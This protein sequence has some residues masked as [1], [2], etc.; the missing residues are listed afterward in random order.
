[1]RKISTYLIA[2]VSLASLAHIA[3]AMAQD[4]AA[5]E[6]TEAEADDGVI[7]VNARRRDES[8]QDV[9]A[10]VNAVSSDVIEK[11]NLRKLQDLEA[12]VPGLSLVPNANGIGSVSTVR[13]VDF[14]VNVSGNNGTIEFYLNDAPLSSGPVF[15]SM[16]DVGQ[17]EVLRGPQ[18]TLKGRASPSGAI[19]IN[20]RKPDLQEVGGNFN[21]TMNDIGGRNVNG[22]LN[23]PIVADKLAVRI[24][25]VVSDDDGSEVQP[26]NNPEKLKNRSQGI[27]AS[28]RSDPFDGKFIADFMYQGFRRKGVQYDQVASFNEIVAGG[29]A[30]PVFIRARDRAAV[31]GF[32]RTNDQ[33]FKIYNWTLQGAL[34]GQRLTYTGQRVDQRLISFAPSDIAGI[35]AVDTVGT[36]RFGQPTDTKANGISHEVRLQNDER[37][38]GIFDYVVGYLNYKNS[39]DTDLFSPTGI[40]IGAPFA[41]PPRLVNIALTPIRRFGNNVEKSIFGNVSAHIGDQFE[42]SGGLRDI[43]YNNVAGLAIG[44]VINPAFN[45]DEKLGK[46]IYSAS[47]KFKF[48]DNAMVYAN[49]GTSWRP[50][51]IAI[52]TALSGAIRPQQAAFLKTAD[53]TSK[54]Y[55]IGLKTDL[56]DRKLRFNLSLYQQ[57]FQNYPY[58]A[59]TGVYTLS[60]GNNSIQQVNFV[61]GVPVKVTGIEAE[62]SAKPMDNFSVGAVFGYAK[63]N[64]SNGIIPCT[65]LN[66]DG[67]PDT[68]AAAPTLAQLEAAVG[69]V[70]NPA[71]A[72]V[73]SCTTS[74]RSN[75]SP[76]FTA[77]LNSEYTASLGNSVDGFVRGLYIYKGK[78][79]SDPVNSFDDQGAFGLLNMY[80]GV[81]DPD[82]GWELSLFGK[83][84]FNTYRVLARSNGPI[85]TPLRGGIPLGGPVTSM[86]NSSATNYFGI[87]RQT[88]PREFGINLRM[89]FGSR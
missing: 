36:N 22:A 2:G 19:T 53:E 33:T 12:V 25:G 38:A 80:M 82:G 40:A 48:N 45:Q 60:P 24:A 50:G 78:S 8:A 31:D 68:L 30:S 54:S 34:V 42:I 10:V 63:G 27:R 15:Q 84:L 70:A 77:S 26:L 72:L 20:L 67:V 28:V 21:A 41:N 85:A 9:P 81:R 52:T 3:P 59:P 17:I 47:A 87:E 89:A 49:M 4:A 37:I 43:K 57:K 79:L 64:I 58:R 69:T 6:A 11:L 66:G 73:D 46:T 86:S 13:G 55:E 18:G 14:N 32:A 23:I 83:N 7:I 61:N 75:N 56:F 71:S 88:D 44:G 29:A 1:M 62:F 51:A 35:F 76:R 39:S 65:D 5:D 16:F 74:S